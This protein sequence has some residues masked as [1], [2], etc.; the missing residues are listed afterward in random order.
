MSMELLGESIDIHGGG[1]D[2]MFPHHENELAQSESCT[3][4]PFSRY[5]LHNG[6][7][8]SGPVAGKVGGRPRPPRR[9]RSPL[10]GRAGSQQARRLEGGRL[11]Q[12]AVC[13]LSAGDDPLLP[14]LDP[15]PQS[16]RAQRR[17][18][19]PEGGKPRPVLS[20][21]RGASAGSPDSDFYALAAPASRKASTRLEGQP[22]GAVPGTEPVAGSL[23]GRDG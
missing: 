15:L 11:R 7:M 6:L 8:Q 21:V 18:D 10:A 3:G 17:P 12:G 23:S 14:P 1:L 4:K 20:P 9:R 13:R 22:A 19:R 2:L 5:W 16:D